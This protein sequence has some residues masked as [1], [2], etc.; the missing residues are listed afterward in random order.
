M[1]HLF[2]KTVLAAALVATAF[3]C[4]K[5]SSDGDAT[6][7]ASLTVAGGFS[8]ISLLSAQGD[9]GLYTP[10]AATDYT[11]IC[12][13]LVSPFTSGS[14]ALDSAGAFSLTIS[15]AA[16]QPIGCMLTKSG[17]IAAVIE[18]TAASSGFS[19]STGGSAYAPESGATKIN[20]P[21]NLTISNGTVAVDTTAIT[22]EGGSGS[23]AGTWA[24]PTGTW[25]IAGFCE[26]KLNE[27]TGA[28]ESQCMNAAGGDMPT[29]VYL[30][31]ISA[32]D[33]V[34]TKYGLSVWESSTARTACGDVEGSVSLGGAWTAV[35]GWNSA[36]TGTPS[37]NLTSGSVDTWAAR[38]IVQSWTN[39]ENNQTQSTCN[40]TV[41]SPGTTTCAD[42]NWTNLGANWGMS[43]AACKLNCIISALSGGG[44]SG[45]M[46]DWGGATCPL[47]YEMDWSKSFQFQNDT[48]WGT[49]GNQAGVLNDGHCVSSSAAVPCADGGDILTADRPQ[50]RFMFGELFISGSMG[51][52]VSKENP[53]TNTYY[54]Q[55]T[56]S[57]VSCTIQRIEKMTIVQTS[58]STAEV[59]VENEML[60][61]S[62]DADKAAC[63]ANSDFARWLSEDNSMTIKLTK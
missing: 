52:V 16:G 59:T 3:G 38:A 34:S 45:G 51:T 30:H 19:G 55:N 44:D 57:S 31:Q 40:A 9:N 58:A 11:M 5:N 62:A 17:A 39:P 41:P 60:D 36:F 12:A 24:D 56:N 47:R 14:S 53:R 6:G 35:G 10:L 8:S 15:G 42:I 43:D 32:T 54:N 46:N 37:V 18:F 49:T 61:L 48:D 7:A 1:N 20:F 29:S 28:Y 27:T 26:N 21:T 25:S 2:K 13:I 50:K 4:S 23:V 22:N 33:G 63:A